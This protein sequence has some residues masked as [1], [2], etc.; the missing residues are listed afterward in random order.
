[1]TQT[2]KLSKL[3][4]VLSDFDFP[5]TRDDVVRMADDVTLLLADGEESLAETVRHS[6]DEEFDSADELL[7][8]V[9]SLLPQR[10]VGEPF[11]SEGDS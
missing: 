7:N 4:S 1:M 2:V 10:A 9:M 5:V 3:D 11:Q 6:S 8:E